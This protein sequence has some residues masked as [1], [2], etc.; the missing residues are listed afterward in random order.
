MND[1]IETDYLVVG[2][3]AAGM[4]FADMLLTHSDARVTIVDRRHAPGGHW[5]DAYPFVHLH[6]PSAFYGVAS[7]PLGADTVDRSG[8]NAGFYGLASAHELRAY[9]AQVM[10]QHFMPSGRVG[11]FPCCDHQCDAPARHRLTSRLTG[12][13]HEVLVRRKLIDTTYLEGKIPATSAPPFEVADGVRCVAAGEVVQVADRPERVVVIGAGK[14]ALDVCVW[15][16]S[17]GVPPTS[18]QWVKPREAWWLN[19][20][21]NQPHTYL[22][23]FYAGIGL[24]LQ[25]MSHTA[26]VDEVFAQLE[27]KGFFLRVDTTVTPTMC[28]GAIVSEAEL[29]LLRRI[30]DVVRLGRVRRLERNRM[31][32]DG[33]VVP[34]HAS[35]LFVHCAAAGLAR[36]PPRPIFEADR[37]TVQPVFWSFACFQFALLGVVEATIERDEDK[38]RLCPPVRYWD[39]PVDYLRT[40]LAAMVHERARAAYPALAA[41]AKETRL[42]P[43]SGLGLHRD[44]PAVSQT[45]AIVK[46]FG[47]AAGSNLMKLLS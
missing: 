13:T 19:R 18:I 15:L 38:N 5:M 12:A 25:A 7:V 42:N 22:P 33:G 40:Y 3:G 24:Q 21:Y 34:T 11:Y 44:D 30:Q 29:A 1:L 26:S 14:T 45:R 36:P 47:A 20:R 4:A 37:V 2:A 32:L 23:D 39:E 41:W 35:T 17:Q 6:Q 46:E 16:L 43:L 9:Y 31:V 28:H 10:Q 8:L 27:A